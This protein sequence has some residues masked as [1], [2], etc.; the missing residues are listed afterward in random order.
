MI[1]PHAYYGKRIGV[2]GL[3]RSGLSACAALDAAGADVTAWDD[4]A[5]RR[6]QSNPPCR[7]LYDLDMADLDA[8]VV[9]PGVPLTHP[10][11]HALIA[12][13]RTASVP[14]IGDIELFA[15]ARRD[16]PH[17]SVVAITGT[18]GKSTTA[19]LMAHV[20]ASAG[21]ETALGGNIGIPALDLP[22]LRT[23]GIYVLELSSYQLDLTHSL[24][25][26]IA[27]LL[28]ITPDHLDRHGTLDNYV[29]AKRRLF[30]MQTPEG[31]A[32]IG[33]DDAHGRAIAA[34]LPQRVIAVSVTRALDD[35]LFVDDT[36]RLHEAR[37]GAACR[38]ADLSGLPTLKGRHNWQ[39]A[40]CV[41]AAARELG[42]SN[43][44]ILTGLESFAGLAHRCEV[45]AEIAGGGLII[46]DSKATNMDAAAT[47]LA[48][49]DRVRWIAGGRLKSPDLSPVE[50]VLQNVRRAYLVGEAAPILE[51]G[52]AGAVETV[53]CET[54]ATA[55][56]CALDD[57]AAGETILF[58]PG[59]ASFDQFSD[60]E[61]RGDAFKAAIRQK[62]TEVER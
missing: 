44:D 22:V 21:R 9:A 53:R 32:I 4:N 46:N 6:T 49:F 30:D 55:A 2:F 27:I 11:P 8:L 7:D 26:E 56:A 36:G 24:D 37:A 60:F 45:V 12:R 33:V 34:A 13:A 16:L 54:V 48:A 61:A 10:Q 14:V 41:F 25:A 58:S 51:S 18:N 17:C 40:A 43:A 5:A 31:L 19:A 38:I 57:R 29:A 47:A 35:G 23:G 39:N 20:L 62:L 28:N 15:A 50:P 42:L 1:V 3:A 59:C 52:L